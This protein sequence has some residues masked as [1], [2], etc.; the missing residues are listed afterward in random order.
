MGLVQE[1]INVNPPLKVNAKMGGEK[2]ADKPTTIH[3]SL[4]FWVWLLRAWP[5]TSQYQTTAVNN[6]L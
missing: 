1:L 5:K 4:Y 6:D 2:V 3:V